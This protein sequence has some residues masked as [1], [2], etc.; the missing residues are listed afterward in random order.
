MDSNARR[1]AIVAQ[2]NASPGSEYYLQ[3]AVQ[4]E[5][6]ATRVRIF[7]D[8]EAR[9]ALRLAMPRPVPVTS[10]CSDPAQICTDR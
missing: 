1:V 6:Q 3:R 8:R 9:E 2:T 4:L 7:A 10:A 5:D